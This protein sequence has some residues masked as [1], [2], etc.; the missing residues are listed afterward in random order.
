LPDEHSGDVALL[1]APFDAN[2]SYMQGPAKAPKVIRATLHSGASNLCAESGHDLAT[3]P[4]FT[5]LGDLDL[6][7][8]ES[9]LDRIERAAQEALAGGARLLTLGGDHSVTLPVLRAYAS[10]CPELT[11]V[12]LDAHPDLYD[13]LDGNRLSHACPF[14]RVMEERLVSRLVQVGVRTLNP[15]QR[16]QAARFGVEIV[17]MRDFAPG[18]DLR[19][20]GSCY[21]SLDLDA[22][23]PAFAPGVS[24]HEPGG[25]TTRDVLG[26]LSRL[27]APLVG[28]DV[29]E[30]NP[31]RDP[32]GTTA[33]LAV[34]LVKE[35]AGRMLR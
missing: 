21:L 24:H 34:K 20:T 16:E 19:L 14:A 17:E 29:V 7:D 3:D 18:L 26:I 30:L 4:R 15:H 10:R 2:S 8:T 22:L 28:A 31:D 5:D 11:V 27:D 6:T 25:F 35:I 13:E 12:Q 23:D 33:A 9:A 32:T 1:G